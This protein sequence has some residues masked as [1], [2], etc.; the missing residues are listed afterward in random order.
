MVDILDLREALLQAIRVQ[1]FE[2]VAIIAD[3]V[4]GHLA[5]SQVGF[6]RQ[7][8]RM[9]QQEEARIEKVLV[10]FDSEG[11]MRLSVDFGAV[12]E[13][14]G[15][16]AERLG[17]APDW[18]WLLPDWVLRH[19][20]VVHAGRAGGCAGT[21]S[22]SACERLFATW[23][24]DIARSANS[25][26]VRLTRCPKLQAFSLVTLSNQTSAPPS[27]AT[28][29]GGVSIISPATLARTFM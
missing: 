14:V 9:R 27:G 15:V 2:V 29:P 22:S 5:G 7:L 4:F 18:V 8:E 12:V 10:R 6:Q 21:I 17:H 26:D 23:T 11:G 20:S 1:L 28:Q 19:E 25:V 24:H 3:V 16:N 13:L